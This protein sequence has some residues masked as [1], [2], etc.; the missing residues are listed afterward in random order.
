M[1]VAEPSSGIIAKKV[2]MITFCDKIE[3]LFS[4]S[5]KEIIPLPEKTFAKLK[6]QNR[7]KTVI[8]TLMRIKKL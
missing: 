7:K 1:S 2:S 4:V 6:I 5:L 3:N 8:M